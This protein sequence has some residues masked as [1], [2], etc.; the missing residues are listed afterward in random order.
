MKSVKRAWRI[1]LMAAILL[2]VFLVAP[3]PLFAHPMGNFSIN[4]YTRLEVN[5]D[6]IAGRYVLDIAEIPTVSEMDRLDAN[7]D[8][9]VSDEERAAYLKA[10][11]VP[12]GHA[13]S[14]TVNG[15]LFSSTLSL[16]AWNFVLAQVDFLPFA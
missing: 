5:G 6:H 3:K 7:H 8:G 4:H 11:A 9:K 12:L 16:K 1:E 15:R 14:L 2:F 13:L 10:Q